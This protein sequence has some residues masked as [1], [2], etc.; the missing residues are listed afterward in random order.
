MACAALLGVALAVPTVAQDGP[1]V[2]VVAEG[3]SNPRGVAI[4]ASGEVWVAEA[5]SAGDQC[6]QGGPEGGE[7]CF[8]P[9]GAISRVVD[10]SVEQVVTG[11]LSGGFGPEVFGVSDIAFIDDSTFY[12]TANLGADPADRDGM[13][14][15]MAGV[16]GWLL[17]GT[18]EGTI[19][20][21]ADIAAFEASDNPEPTL[22]DS[23][24]YSVAVVD[25]GAV[26]ADAGGN[27]LLMVD[28]SG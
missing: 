25:G 24:P 20:P 4:A 10:G 19:E 5:G 6:M 2:E 11:L 15:E 12:V 21:F 22:V 7:I 9:T 18:T 17:R 26:V 13:P 1:A 3:L 28:D 14:P 8:G 23:N 16:A 27:D